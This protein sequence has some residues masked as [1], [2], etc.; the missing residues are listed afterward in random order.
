MLA[1]VPDQLFSWTIDCERRFRGQLERLALRKTQSRAFRRFARRH[2]QWADSLFDEYF[3]THGA[4]PLLQRY[5]QPSG[6]PSPSELAAAWFAQCKAPGTSIQNCDT[7]ELTRVAAD[8]L[9]CFEAEWRECQR[10]F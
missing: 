9:Q 3:V 5:L 10:N 8:F 2:P 7:L 6:R 1:L 4:A